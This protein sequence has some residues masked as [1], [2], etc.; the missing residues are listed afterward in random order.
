MPEING[1]RI[2]VGGLYCKPPWRPQG[3]W[4]TLNGWFVRAVLAVLIA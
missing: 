1:Q 4:A 3:F 2:F